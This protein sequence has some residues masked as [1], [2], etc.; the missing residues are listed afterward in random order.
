MSHTIKHVRCSYCVQYDKE[1][2]ASCVL[3]NFNMYVKRIE[4]TEDRFCSI[5]CLFTFII[6]K[7]FSDIL[8]YVQ[9]EKKQFYISLLCYTSC[10]RC[11]EGLKY[12]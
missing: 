5:S 11:F 2:T 4:N 10:V 12:Y 9:N 8:T 1:I 7:W 6:R 3:Y